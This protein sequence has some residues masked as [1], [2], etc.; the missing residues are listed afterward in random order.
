[1]RSFVAFRGP[2]LAFHIGNCFSGFPLGMA[3]TCSVG[4]RW[5][6]PRTAS[7]KVPVGK[8]QAG[9]LFLLAHSR[10][11]VSPPR[12]SRTLPPSHAGPAACF[13]VA[14]V[15]L[16]RRPAHDSKNFLTHR[17]STTYSSH[18]LFL[19]PTKFASFC[20]LQ[21]NSPT[22]LPQNAQISTQSGH[23]ASFRR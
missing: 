11:R 17:I 7:A 4:Q 14:P 10:K 9:G 19:P 18:L 21:H 12:I 2:R 22:Q 16:L 20:Q 3:V 6:I 8:A 15:P 13:C 23:P 5:W 1:M